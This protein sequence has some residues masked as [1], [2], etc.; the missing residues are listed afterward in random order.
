LL[1]WTL[2][3]EEWRWSWLA[4]TCPRKCLKNTSAGSVRGHEDHTVGDF[5]ISF[6]LWSEH[7]Q[8]WIWI[9]IGHE[10][11]SWKINIFKFVFDSTLYIHMLVYMK[12]IFDI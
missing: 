7:G 3:S 12:C 6:G 4:S 8:K 10:E 1:P 2:C 5:T 9:D 11:K